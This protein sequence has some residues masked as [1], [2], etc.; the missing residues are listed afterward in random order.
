MQSDILNK[1]CLVCGKMISS[2][3]FSLVGISKA[4]YCLECGKV[5]ARYNSAKGQRRLASERRKKRTASLKG[6]GG[7]RHFCVY[8][9]LWVST[10][11]LIKVMSSWKRGE[12][13]FIR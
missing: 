13:R 11:K 9:L 2:E 10:D 12:I 7:I 6:L 3:R 4:K 5:M 1:A 8:S